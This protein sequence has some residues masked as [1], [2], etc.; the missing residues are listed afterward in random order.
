[1]PSLESLVSR[2]PPIH[3]KRETKGNQT[4]NGGKRKTAFLCKIGNGQKM[5][6][7]NEGRFFHPS[8]FHQKG[9]Q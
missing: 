7:G 2:F 3:G 6:H 4:G 5:K 1:M 8:R 9:T